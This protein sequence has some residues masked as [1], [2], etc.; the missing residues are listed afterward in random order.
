MSRHLLFLY[1]WEHWARAGMNVWMLSVGF[2]LTGSQQTGFLNALKD[3]PARY[4]FWWLCGDLACEFSISP[5]STLLPLHHSGFGFS[6][7]K[8]HSY[9]FCKASGAS[10]N[11]HLYDKWHLNIASPGTRAALSKLKSSLARKLQTESCRPLPALEASRDW[12]SIRWGWE[13]AALWARLSSLWL[14]GA[15]RQGWVCLEH[16]AAAEVP[17]PLERLA[18]VPCSTLPQVQWPML[19]PDIELSS[20]NLKGQTQAV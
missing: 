9:S 7:H 13:E 19:S 20:T 10:Q 11:I 17:G 2:I 6:S 4:P 5:T 18:G 3:S 12:C 15:A 1:R 14:A 8:S 16:E